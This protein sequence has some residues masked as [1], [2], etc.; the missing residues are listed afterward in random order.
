MSITGRQVNN[1][2]PPINLTFP[3]CN[4]FKPAIFDGDLCHSIDVSHRIMSGQRN[5]GFL[6]EKKLLLAVDKESSLID[7]EAPNLGISTANTANIIPQREKTP[8]NSILIHLNNLVRYTDARPGNLGLGE[9]VKIKIM[10][11]LTC[12]S[13]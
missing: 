1:L 4:S 5:I 7:S 2:N 10:T 8:S 12:F 13:M 9:I 3:V 11:R 6:K